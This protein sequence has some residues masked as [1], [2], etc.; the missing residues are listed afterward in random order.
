MRAGALVGALTLGCVLVGSVAPAVEPTAHRS[1]L[2]L[3][4][5]T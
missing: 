3:L 1:I 4:S 5:L 2:P